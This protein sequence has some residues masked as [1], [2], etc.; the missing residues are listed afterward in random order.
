MNKLN[1]AISQSK[2]SKPY[3]H[4]IIIDLLV[5]LT[6][7]GK[8]RSLRAFKKS[9]DKLTIEQK[10][11]LRAYTDSI[12]CMLQAGL[13]FHEIKE[14]LTKEKAVTVPQQNDFNSN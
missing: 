1:Q 13:A 12:I 11:T 6:T 14:F 8:Y 4:K 2:N 9:G 10:E 5:Q 3:Y 7:E